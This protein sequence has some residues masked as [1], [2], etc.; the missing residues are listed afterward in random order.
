M[1]LTA[2]EALSKQRRGT[3]APP[4]LPVAP[5]TSTVVPASADVT[6]DLDTAALQAALDAGGRVQLVPRKTYYFKRQSL[7]APAGIVIG[8][9]SVMLDVPK[10]TTLVLADGQECPLLV[11][12]GHAA[13]LGGG[14]WST[15]APYQITGGGTLDKG[16]NSGA[17]N[18]LHTAILGGTQCVIEKMTFKTSGKATNA[19]K[20]SLL[21]HRMTWSSIEKLYFDDVVSDGLHLH[22]GCVG[23]R[24]GD[25][26]G[27]T[28]DDLV[29]ITPSD[30]PAYAWPGE[31]AAYAATG[32]MDVFDVSI[33]N[34]FT[35]QGG[36]RAFICLGGSVGAS[37]IKVRAVRV[38][39]VAGVLA[40]TQAAVIVGD[41]TAQ[42]T[43]SGGFLDDIT[44]DTIAVEIQDS[45]KAIVSI[46]GNA[47]S[48]KHGTIRL[49][50]IDIRGKDVAAA[51]S[52]NGK[53]RTLDV[54]GVTGVTA[55]KAMAAV[56]MNATGNAWPSID[57][58][59]VDKV[60]LT[61][62]GTRGGSLIASA[63]AGQ[64]LGEVVIGPGV[65][66]NNP[67]WLADVATATTFRCS[68]V[69]A[70]NNGGI[71][72]VRTGAAVIVSGW[73]GCTADTT[74]STITATGTLRSLS[75]DLPLDISNAQVTAARA[76]GD[77]CTARVT[78]GNVKANQSCEYSATLGHWV[79]IEGSSTV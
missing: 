12:A 6:G 77:R 46:G 64:T 61:F 70:A 31:D 26:K 41:D 38:R 65:Y 36:S 72:N 7:I 34:I 44:I 33:D 9:V 15:P 8:R 29:A 4:S 21:L 3:S 67:A 52:N 75:R 48:V 11:D 13:L 27:K 1:A 49:R 54:S 73:T 35:Q 14:S 28:G 39:N 16:K 56:I 57:R 69:H 30:Y 66:I 79:G 45:T 19:S 42:A 78:N 10:S 18:G 51:V 55:T 68:G 76:D 22:S 63:T 20:F 25:V 17:G 2:T 5:L 23:L 40:G 71:F 43:T 24:I 58:L 50:N 53:V 47:S 62:T 59:S 32:A 74:S 37:S 60:D